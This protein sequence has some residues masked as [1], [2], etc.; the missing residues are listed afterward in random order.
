[1]QNKDILTLAIETSC[2]ETACA[3]LKNG[4]EILSNEV[5]T[6]IEIHQTFGGVVPEI[7]SRNH[8]EKISEVIRKAVG[9]AGV[10]LEQVDE[11]A[12][13]RKSVV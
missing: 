11:I 10:T 8:L 12:V 6:Q 3:V 4:R 13:D 2:D 1:M 5:Y 9:D 7:A